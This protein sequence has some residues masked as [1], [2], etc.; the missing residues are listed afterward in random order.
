MLSIHLLDID[1]NTVFQSNAFVLHIV[2]KTYE[3]IFFYSVLF[4]NIK[5]PLAKFSSA[6]TLI[7]DISLQSC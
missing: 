6:V 1:R 5:I 2:Q 4:L 7:S 3:Y